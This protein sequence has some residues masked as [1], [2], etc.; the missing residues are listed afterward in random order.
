MR[1]TI[2]L[3]LAVALASCQTP[4]ATVSAPPGN[5][6][7]VKDFGAK[8]DGSTDDTAA[9]QAAIVRIN[10]SGKPAELY[11]PPGAY[12]LATITSGHF[13]NWL[14]GVS[15]GG[16]GTIK[17]GDNVGDYAQIFLAAPGAVSNVFVDGLTIDENSSHNRFTGPLTAKNQRTVFYTTTGENVSY[18]NAAFLNGNGGNTIVGDT[19]TNVTVEKCTWVNW[20]ANAATH[21]NSMLY[22][23][24]Y[25]AT[26]MG[27]EFSAAAGGVAFTAIEIHRSNKIV[28]HNVIHGYAVGVIY[29][30]EEPAATNIQIDDNEMSGMLG[31]GV[32][33]WATDG[34]VSRIQTAYNK[35]DMIAGESVNGIATL[36]GL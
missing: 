20:G 16:S 23:N 7:N 9:I 8:G 35:I 27:N 25:G 32:Q 29:S 14:G 1:P 3:L 17:I 31:Q 12:L 22:L 24:G 30:A 28:S 13:L 15:F 4:P 2:P 34:A 5:V 10:A 11:F 6:V 26:V 19:T 33:I 36:F 21:D 18:R